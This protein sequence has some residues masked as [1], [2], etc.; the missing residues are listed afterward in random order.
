[1]N[2]M[3]IV[4]RLKYAAFIIYE[5]C[6]SLQEFCF[7]IKHLQSIDMCRI[8]FMPI[9]LLFNLRF[10]NYNSQNQNYFFWVWLYT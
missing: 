2:S 4:C 9:V 6:G 10:F 8:W 1:M 7:Y 5:V 3:H